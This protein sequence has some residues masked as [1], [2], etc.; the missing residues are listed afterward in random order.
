MFFLN[1]NRWR[2]KIFDSLEKVSSWCDDIKKRKKSE[3]SDFSAWEKLLGEKHVFF[4]S[5]PLKIWY[6]GKNQKVSSWCD[7]FKNKK[8]PKKVIFSA[9]GKLLTKTHVFLK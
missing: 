8:N 1:Q 7:I 9:Y 2:Y 3:K 5:K 6:F 4:K